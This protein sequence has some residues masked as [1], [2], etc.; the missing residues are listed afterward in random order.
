MGLLS[1]RARAGHPPV[2]SLP[3]RCRGRVAIRAACSRKVA[4][5]SVS[6]APCVVRD[7]SWTPSACSTRARRRHQ[8]PTR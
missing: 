1:A 8:P 4:P 6:T 2:R 7:R 3:A 5:A